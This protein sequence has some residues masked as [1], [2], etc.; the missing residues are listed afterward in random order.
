MGLDALDTAIVFGHYKTAF[1]LL[2]RFPE[3]INL[4]K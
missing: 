4:L 1:L 3:K 2:E